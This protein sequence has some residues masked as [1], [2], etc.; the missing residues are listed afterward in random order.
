MK[1]GR[2]IRDTIHHDFGSEKRILQKIAGGLTY[3]N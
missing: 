1:E 2:F 3:V